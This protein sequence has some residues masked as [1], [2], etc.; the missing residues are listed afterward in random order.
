MAASLQMLPP[1]NLWFAPSRRPFPRPSFAHFAFPAACMRPKILVADRIGDAGLALLRESNEVDCR[2]DLGPGE[3]CRSIRD[4]DAMIISSDTKLG[5]ELFECSRGKLRVVGIAGVGIDNVDLTAANEHRCLVVNAPAAST[6]AVAEHGIALLTAMARNVAHA[7][8]SVKSGRRERMNFRGMQM[9]GKTLAVIG[10]GEVGFEVARRAKGLG[11]QVIAYDP[12]A[13]S[14]RAQSIGIELVG[15][16][17]AIM[18]ADVISLHMHLTPTTRKMLRDETFGKM[19]KG[20][21]ILNVAHRDLIDAD[22]LVR[23]LDAGIVSQA[24]LDME[25]ED[26][27]PSYE[28]LIQHDRVI[29]T[30]NIG[31]C[32]M[33]AQD[34]LAIEIA[35]GVNKALNG[36]LPHTVVNE[37]MVPPEVLAELKPFLDLANSLGKLA[38]QLIAGSGGLRSVKVAYASARESDQLDT[39]LLRVGIIKGLL[40]PISS[41]VV[42]WANADSIAKQRKLRIIEELISLHGAPEYPLEFM[43]LQI[44]NVE[45]RFASALSKAGEIEIEGQVKNGVPYLSKL[46][47]FEVD[48][49]LEGRILICRSFDQP[50]L[51]GRVGSILGEANVNIA[52]MKAGRKL[53]TLKLD[54]DPTEETL[55]KIGEI[56][57]VQEYIFLKM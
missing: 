32:T 21:H 8:I 29:V 45:T 16:D 4:F 15:P 19:K 37:P 30:P 40:E 6:L 17:K 36:H 39:K 22:A 49:A 18:S 53:L 27:P 48:F 13:S 10:F 34:E 46:G 24:A 50:G 2:F 38:V 54:E 11:M 41:V 1:K 12:Y 28:T 25:L 3:L 43:Q 35:E 23:A 51:I 42:N 31:D 20:V 26:L 33:E 9:A 52:L 7:T 5:K 56:P 47:P 57:A 44:A 14:Y 55:K